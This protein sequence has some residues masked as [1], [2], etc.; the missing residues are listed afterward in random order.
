[1]YNVQ[2]KYKS[3]KNINS[4]TCHLTPKWH[5]TAHSGHHAW[6]HLSVSQNDVQAMQGTF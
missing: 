3:A 2:L 4:K 1:M 5:P 6:T